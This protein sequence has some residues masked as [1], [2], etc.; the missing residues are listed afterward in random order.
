[1]NALQNAYFYL[2]YPPQDVNSTTAF[3]TTGINLGG[4]GAVGVGGY[5]DL[6][7]VISFGA[8]TNAMD[9]QPKIQHSSDNTNW[10][11][12]T[13]ATFTASLSASSH[14]NKLLIGNVRTGG[15][16]KQYVRAYFDCGAS[17]TLLSVLWVGLNPGDGINGATEIARGVAAGALDRFTVAP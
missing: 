14:D 3:G 1:M 11:D 4:T 15:G 2:D 8:V 13:G 12:I 5:S 9:A 16:L 10:T 7:I 6:F 17:A